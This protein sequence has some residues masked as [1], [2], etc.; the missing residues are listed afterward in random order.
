M[1]ETL[2][3]LVD[4]DEATFEAVVL[5]GSSERPVVVDFWAPWC[6]PCLMLG[7]ILERVV[8][9]QGGSVL[10]AKLNTDENP[11]ISARY[12]IRGIPAVKAFQNG[13]VVNEFVGAVPEPTVRAFVAQLAPSPHAAAIREARVRLHAGDLEGARNV[14]DA[15]PMSD[16]SRADA[17]R[18]LA[19][20]ALHE[21][22][23]AAGSPDT[24][25]ARVAADPQDAAAVLGVA[26][27]EL[28]EG[29]F[30]QGMERLIPLIAARSSAA[31]EARQLALLAF[32]AEANEEAVRSW[33]VRLSAALY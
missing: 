30:D 31:E 5:K 32:R 10:L 13:Q 33:Q 25:A 6:G 1:N 24:L 9:D 20:I 15:V 19:V 14:L 17:D 18:L 4:V 27:H 3:T 26:A 12:G 22:A 2:Q 29:R 21:Q 28:A 8:A 11:A 16:P 7:P 23:A